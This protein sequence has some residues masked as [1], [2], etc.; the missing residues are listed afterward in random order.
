MVVYTEDA[1]LLGFRRP[2]GA[3]GVRNHVAVMPAVF[4]ANGV[5]QKIAESL[6]GVAVLCHPLGCSQVGLDLEL[7]AR[8]LKGLGRNPNVAAILVVGLGCERLRASELVE[9]IAQTG[10]PVE[11]ISI[12]QE[13]GTTRTVEKGRRLLEMLIRS[14]AGQARERCGIGELTVAV[15]CGGSDGSSLIA[16]NP[17]IG[18]AM[19]LL[20][21]HGGAVVFSEVTEL[22]GTEAAIAERAASPQV[23]EMAGAMLQRTGANLVRRRDE[24]N[25]KRSALISRGNVEGGLT[26][27]TEKSLGSLVKSG[28]RPIVGVLEYAEE[29]PLGPGVFLMDAP[30]HDAESVT[31]MVAG[32]AQVVVFATG[33][34]TPAGFPI[35]PVIK[36]TGN[37]ATYA[38]MQENIDLD[39]SSVVDGLVRPEQMGQRIFQ[40]ILEVAFGQWTKSEIL[41]HNELLAIWRAP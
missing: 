31:G 39:A 34:G 32:G 30:G 25:G 18:A 22:Q 41:G 9:A 38:G 33:R 29:I 10:K 28:S 5:A 37:P 13:G 1:Y 40:M 11:W 23:A 24:V 3:V 17:S 8:T 36:V 21:D 15:E 19:D 26:T 27:L 6:E 12:Q 7:T 16:A 2:N 20:V 4:C 14:V 35:A